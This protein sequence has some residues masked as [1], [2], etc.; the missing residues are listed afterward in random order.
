MV[1]VADGPFG[2]QRL[3]QDTVWNVKDEMLE[4][5]QTELDLISMPPLADVNIFFSV[6]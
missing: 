6:K 1:P 5:P 4:Y 3:F 2:G